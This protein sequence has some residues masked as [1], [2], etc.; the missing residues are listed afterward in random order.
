[1]WPEDLSA[2]PGATNPGYINGDIGI[3]DFELTDGEMR[4]MRS[5]NKEARFF[6]MTLPRVEEM[7]RTYPLA[8]REQGIIR[9]PRVIRRAGTEQTIIFRTET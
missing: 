5:L 1:M 3:F 4:T 6:N 9:E 2:F 7:V 8:D